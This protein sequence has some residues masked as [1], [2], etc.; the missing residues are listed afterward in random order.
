MRPKEVHR[1]IEPC[2]RFPTTSVD[3]D[4]RYKVWVNSTYPRNVVCYRLN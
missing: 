3:I 1:E 2:A 4:S